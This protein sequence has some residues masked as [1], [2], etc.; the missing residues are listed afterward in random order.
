[1]YVVLQAQAQVMTKQWVYVLDQY[2]AVV[3]LRGAQ[4]LKTLTEK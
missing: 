3:F 2:V 1:M 4:K